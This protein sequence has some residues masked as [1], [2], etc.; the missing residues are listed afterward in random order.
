MSYFDKFV[1]NVEIVTVVEREELLIPLIKEKD[2]FIKLVGD[3]RNYYTHFGKDLKEK[4]AKGSELYQ[5]SDKLAL[6]LKSCLL[7]EIG[8]TLEKQIEIFLGNWH[9]DFVKK[10]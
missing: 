2:V 7:S 6:L 4:A 10:S 9:Y 3:T 8:I 1:E 5:L